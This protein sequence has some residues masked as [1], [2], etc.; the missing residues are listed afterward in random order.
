[1]NSPYLDKLNAIIT[2]D[3]SLYILDGWPL[4][5]LENILKGNYSVID[6]NSFLTE[7][8]KEDYG[9]SWFNS[10]FT[11]ITQ[12]NNNIVT[13]AQFVCLTKM[14]DPSYF[15]D[16]AIILSEGLRIYFPLLE[17]E[18][19]EKIDSGNLESRDQNMPKHH[20]EHLKIGGKFFF[21]QG[22][23]FDLKR[24]LVFTTKKELSTEKNDSSVL[25]DA[26]NSNFELELVISNIVHLNTN[27]SVH[28]LY[29]PKNPLS[30]S[31]I[32]RL[33]VINNYKDYFDLD[34]S[35]GKKTN[36]VVH[37]KVSTTSIDL[38]K[39]YWGNN[40][41][42]RNIRVY[43]DPDISNE[44]IEISQG[45]IV[46]LIISEVEKGRNNI[47]PRDLFLTAPTGSGKS[48]LFQLPSF[49]S[50]EH[51]DMVIVISPLIALMKD[52]VHALISDR[53]FTKVAYLNSE[54]SFMDREVVLTQ[55]HAGEIDVL[56]LSPEL[57]L[58]YNISHFI[59]QRNLGL[60]VIDEAHLITTWGRDF[61][62][63][64]W[65]LGNHLRKVKKY[66]ELTF[67]IVAVTATAVYGGMNDM[68]FDT[69]SSL[70]LNNPYVF[71]GSV[72]R[73]DISFAITNNS[74][75]DNN[76]KFDNWKINQTADFIMK[77]SLNTDLK[78]LV[79]APYT[80]H[81]KKIFQKVDSQIPSKSGVYYGNLDSAL[82][83][84]SF[85][86]FLNN[87]I[88]TIIC[89]KAFGMG[90]D[91]PDIQ[92]VYHHAPSGHL[93][94]YIQEVG[95]LARKPDIRGFA[96]LNYS[97]KDKIYSKRLF[98]MSALHHYQVQGVL[99]KLYEKFSQTKNQN[100]LISVDDFS[101]IF[102][103]VMNIDQ[104]VLTA[105]M[106]IEKDYLEKF[107]FNVVIARPKKLFVKVYARINSKYFSLFSSKFKGLFKELEYS[108]M[109]E[110][111]FHII[112]IDLDLL[113]KKY[114]SK[115]NFPTLKYKFYSN[116]LF[117][118][119]DMEVVPQLKLEL[120]IKQDL[121]STLSI[122]DFFIKKI[123]SSFTVLSGHY[124]SESD[125]EKEISKMVLKPTNP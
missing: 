94:D 9:N 108:R 17:K 117:S 7:C 36:K 51:G 86:S 111:G 14:L 79:Y 76:K 24:E 2:D 39:K 99:K 28:I 29:S 63:D 83:E 34:I 33:C 44:Q 13:L 58:S 55:A 114:F 61:R 123:E 31:I 50:S 42:F 107:R 38:L 25:V 120:I 22:Y 56:Y 8:I 64:Y 60:V 49:Y 105:L 37:N 15:K 66:N 81:V 90:I 92:V 4:K 40:A 113:C 72:R 93:P 10:V 77:L 6:S 52:Q 78:L 27:S 41:D 124:F 103:D 75:K 98:G 82:K 109:N 3:I 20:I 67:P 65:F 106:M 45:Q 16:K 18:F 69:L 35:I 91:I 96:A 89:T 23:D 102:D 1:M 43:E 116:K 121:E 59:G 47:M 68:V 119:N 101:H 11:K 80:S 115:E 88:Q 110:R 30:N 48:L 53:G 54:L 122:F 70:E 112:S 71:I 32:D 100:L 97:E 57:L 21:I 5:E 104:K 62:V 46:D 84:D 73:D 85:H 74:L 95:R 118:I 26:S 125:L 87:D 12:S 19:I